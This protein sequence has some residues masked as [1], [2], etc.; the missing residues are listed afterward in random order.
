MHVSAHDMSD[1]EHTCTRSMSGARTAHHMLY[2]T[3]TQG[4][5][6]TVDDIHVACALYMLQCRSKVH[7]HDCACHRTVDCYNTR[8]IISLKHY[9]LIHSAFQTLASRARR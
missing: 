1:D 6:G 4:Y 5:T 3:V 9:Q 7:T 2:C 8:P